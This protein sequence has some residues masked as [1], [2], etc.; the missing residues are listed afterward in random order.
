MQVLVTGGTGF[1]GSHTCY[2]LLIAGHQ[3]TLV[4][5]LSNSKRDVLDRIELIAGKRPSFIEGDVRDR[6]LL[7]NILSQ[8]KF[9]AVIHFA[10]LKSVG[11][12]VAQPLRY[13]DCN[14]GGTLVLC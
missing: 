4:D 9:D 6:A 3:V 1:I 8:H 2:A 7:K 5:D 12:S 11:E 10:G 13:Y 14:V